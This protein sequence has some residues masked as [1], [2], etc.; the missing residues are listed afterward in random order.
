MKKDNMISVEEAEIM[1]EIENANLDMPAAGRR[2]PMRYTHCRRHGAMHGRWPC[3]CW[4]R[5]PSLSRW[6]SRRW[7]RNMDTPSMMCFAP[8]AGWISSWMGQAKKCNPPRQA[9]NDSLYTNENYQD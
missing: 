6:M 4:V 7:P 9:T 5:R 8:I 1:A 3:T 2:R